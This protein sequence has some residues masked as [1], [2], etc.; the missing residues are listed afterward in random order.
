MNTSIIRKA[1]EGKDLV[2][3]AYR[4]YPRIAEPHIYGIK[5]G[6]RQLLVYQSGGLASS[7]SIVGWRRIDLEDISGFKLAGSKFEGPREPRPLDYDDWDT[8]I[9]KVSQP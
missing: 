7:G 1:I 9:S 2:E 6:K 8:V 3:F 5:A 4:G